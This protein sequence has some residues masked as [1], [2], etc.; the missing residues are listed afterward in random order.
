MPWQS[1]A[2]A[3]WP[4]KFIDLAGAHGFL[5]GNRSYTPINVAGA[6]S[7]FVQSLDDGG[8]VV[9]TS[10][11]AQAPRTASSML[12]VSTPPLDVPGASGTFAQSIDSTSGVTGYY[13][14]ATGQ[15]GFVYHNGAYATLDDPLA[16]N[17]RQGPPMA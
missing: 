8:E 3:G 14:D 9:G 16:F 5:Y 1:I 2:A 11:T 4:G 13:T 10:P 12:A 7:T 17:P 15:H 6:T